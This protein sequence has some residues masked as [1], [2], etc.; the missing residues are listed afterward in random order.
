M[1]VY[2]VNFKRDRHIS[3]TKNFLRRACHAVESLD[4]QLA[5]YAI[6]AW[7]DS[8]MSYTAYKTGG[9]VGVSLLKSYVGEQILA[10]SVRDD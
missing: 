6:V 8:G 1:T 3:R 2:Q 7:D 10:V 5:G 9:P 4:G